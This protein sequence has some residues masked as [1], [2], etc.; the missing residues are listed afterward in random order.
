MGFDGETTED[1]DKLPAFI[2]ESPMPKAMV[3]VL[4]AIPMTQLHAQMEAEGRLDAA[5]NGDQFG[6]TNFETTMDSAVL[7]E[8]YGQVL[9]DIYTPQNYFA[10]CLNL[11]R[12]GPNNKH[13]ML[14]HRP[15]LA[16]TAAVNSILRQGLLSEYRIQYWKFLVK[17][18]RTMPEKFATGV[19][20]A[21]KFH[22][23][24]KYTHRDVLPR[25][26]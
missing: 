26:T 4:Q 13:S 16:I 7:R 21:I 1:L 2:N 18:A 11:M 17:V 3:G 24:H 14:R 20:H 12:L 19:G 8:K 22:H 9:S 5:F 25:L 23:L 6:R 10:R 15:K